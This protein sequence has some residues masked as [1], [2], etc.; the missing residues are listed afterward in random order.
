[1][2]RYKAADGRAVESWWTET[3]LS[4]GFTLIELMIVIAIISILAAFALPAY[5]DYKIK[6]YVAA[7][8]ELSAEVKSRIVTLLRYDQKNP[9]KQR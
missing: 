8:L 9:T 2:V 3:A 1:M 6:S 7:G 4:R 5:R